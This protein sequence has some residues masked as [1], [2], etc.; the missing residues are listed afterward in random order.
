V[1]TFGFLGRLHAEKG[2]HELLEAFAA[3]AADRPEVRLVVAGDGP[4]E[5]AVR[6]F[7][8]DRGAGRV[9]PAGRIPYEQLSAFFER[10]DCL[11]LPSYSEGLPLSVLEAAAHKRVL[12][13]TDVSDLRE[14]FGDSLIVCA[15][16]DPADLRAAMERAMDAPESGRLSYDRAIEQLSI[17]HVARAMAERLG[18]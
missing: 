6:R 8:E 9:E 11:V 4:E 7:A 1:R 17:D 15:K 18:A 12:V 2:I 16:R 14:L 13:T 10:I 5:A 3:L